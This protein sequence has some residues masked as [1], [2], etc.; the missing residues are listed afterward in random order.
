MPRNIPRVVRR[1]ARKEARPAFKKAITKRKRERKAG[2]VK[3]VIDHN[4]TNIG[5]T[6]RNIV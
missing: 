5:S 1:K 4:F 6:L 2:E 3:F